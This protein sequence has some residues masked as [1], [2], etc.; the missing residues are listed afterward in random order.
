MD[1]TDDE[2]RAIVATD[3]SYRRYK[4]GLIALNAALPEVL[5]KDTLANVLHRG[6][7]YEDTDDEYWRF[8]FRPGPVARSHLKACPAVPHY[9]D[10]ICRQIVSK[11]ERPQV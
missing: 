11:A 10:E 5:G 3:I 1:I 8:V 7:I 9:R 2:C 4:A 6:L